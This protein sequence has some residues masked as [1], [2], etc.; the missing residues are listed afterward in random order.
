MRPYLAILSARFRVLLQYRAAAVAGF[1]TQLFWGL[2]RMM[3]F[4]AFYENAAAAAPMSE[5]HVITYIWL[6]QAFFAMFPL[7]VDR[8]VHNLIR[9]GNVA[10]ELLRPADLYS[11]FYTRMLAQRVAPTLLRSIPMLIIATVAGWIRWPGPA[12]LAAWAA[13]MLGALMLSCALSTLMTIS[14]F[15]TISGQGI[16]RLTMGMGF[17]LSGMVIPLP[18]FPDSLQPVLTALPFRGVCDAPY[19]VFTGHIPLSGVPLALAHQLGWVAALVVLGRWLLARATRRL[20][21]QGG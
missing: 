3:I 4:A 9:T 2:I 5:D 7:W 13:T 14:M 6:G 1:G 11:L 10:Y 19:R 15:W 20:V 12:A 21:I 17:L 8:D 18:L 16:A